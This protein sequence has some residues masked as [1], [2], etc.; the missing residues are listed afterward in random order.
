MFFNNRSSQTSK[1]VVVPADKCAQ[2]NQI[3]FS[4]YKAELTQITKESGPTSAF[5]LLKKQYS[6]VEYVKSQCHQLV[7]VIGR[8]AY[9]RYGNVADTFAH[10]DQFC[11]AG[12]YHGLME[13]VADEQGTAKFLNSL[14][15]ICSEIAAKARFSFNHYNCV[16]GL[17]HGVMEAEDGNLFKALDDC[18]R[19]SDDWERSS[20]YGGVFMQNIMIV[21]SP[22]ET[23]DHSSAYLKADEPMYPCTAIANKYKGQC[24][25]MQTSYALQ[26]EDYNF[27]KVFKLCDATPPAYRDTCYNSIGR[28]ASGQSISDVDRTKAVCLMGS[29]IVA[30]SGCVAGAAKDFVSYFHSDVEAKRLC[31]ALPS[32]LRDSCFNTVAGY[33]ST[34]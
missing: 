7:H 25:L 1:A 15:T 5:A 12:Y 34:F 17:G 13:Q 23:V 10:G 26:V 27:A 2:S 20:C 22:D 11:W 16:H 31:A 3:T 30:R 8:A 14:N 19:I 24:Y 9:A 6:Q 33:Y 21:Q 32:E 28:D 18:D 4:C 29:D